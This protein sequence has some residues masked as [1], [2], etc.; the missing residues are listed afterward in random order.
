MFNKQAFRAKQVSTCHQSSD[1][2][3]DGVKSDSNEILRP[4]HCIC[5]GNYVLNW[6]GCIPHFLLIDSGMSLGI[7]G[8]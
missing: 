4:H 3:T 2:L 6:T 8:G 1:G 7:L 5:F